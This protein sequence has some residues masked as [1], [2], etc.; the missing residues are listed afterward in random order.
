MHSKQYNRAALPLYTKT[1]INMPTKLFLWF[2]LSLCL[3]PVRPVLAEPADD[4]EKSSIETVYVTATRE[5]LGD[6]LSPGVVSVAFPDA[7]KGEHKSLP[8]ILDQIAGVYVRRVSGTGQYTTASIRG[9]S[10]SQVN[11]YIDGVPYNTSSE[12]AV[13]LSTLPISNVERVEVY[14]GSTPARFS[15]A[16]L[17]GAIN[18]VTKRAKK[19]GGSVSV[20]ARS[21]GGEQYAASLNIPILSSSLL[22]SADS[23]KSDGDFKYPLIS[24]QWA[25]TVK[26]G[27]GT[28]LCCKMV[29]GQIQPALASELPDTRRRQ[30]N[31]FKKDNALI[32]W[33]NRIITAKLSATEMD[34]Y[35]PAAVP[36]RYYNSV[37]IS[38][39][40]KRQRQEDINGALGWH[41]SFGNVDLSINANY[42]RQNK[43]FDALDVKP[44]VTGSGSRW[45]SYLTERY[46]ATFD[47]VYSVGEST[48][49]SHRIEFHAE[50]KHE[51]MSNDANGLTKTSI[52]LRWFERE[53]T[54]LQLQNTMRIKPLG[55]LQIAPVFRME[56]IDGPALSS[57]T[58]TRRN[59]LGYPEGDYGWK[60][61][62]GLNLKKD[63]GNWQIFSNYGTY[64][65]YPNFYEIYGDGVYIKPNWDSTWAIVPLLRETGYNLDL[66]LGWNGAFSDNVRGGIRATLFRR[67]TKNAITLYAT[68]VGAKY[69]NS[70]S[71]LTHGLELEGSLLFGDRADWQFAFTAQE[72]HYIKGTYYYF[73]G[74]AASERVNSKLKTLQAPDMVM[75]TRLNVYFLDKH[76]TSFIELKYTGKK[77]VGQTDSWG[78]QYEEPLATLGLGAH[79]QFDVGLRISLGVDDIFNAGPKQEI[80]IEK[81]KD[82][83]QRAVYSYW[84]CAVV[85]SACTSNPDNQVTEMSSKERRNVSYPLQGRT[86]YATLAYRF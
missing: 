86:W 15:G 84:N 45:S 26:W 8:D 4:S 79:Y 28:G 21:F 71:T 2:L 73:G 47:V 75:S 61:S 23:E 1:A 50:Y 76:L 34:R 63:F 27:D 44:S 37:D 67:H 12:V 42:S 18:I 17:G 29:G 30:S 62:Y 74:V 25:D 83:T 51:T 54:A 9:S 39:E 60:Y 55:D 36:A 22:I 66:G 77:F 59:P 70:G 5:D 38:K 35:L 81:G 57:L 43:R 68:P 65:R 3:L 46:G 69:I 24:H 10:P 72:G 78:W 11:I 7:V 16:P 19:L 56:R 14:R 32:T 52:W 53:H 49:V 41:D 20:G 6:L 40:R 85:D 33:S 82:E 48:P 80:L 31:S 13:D 64:H 58:S